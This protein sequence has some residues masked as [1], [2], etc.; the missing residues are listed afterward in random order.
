MAWKKKSALTSPGTPE[1]DSKTT[2]AGKRR[3]DSERGDVEALE[4][5]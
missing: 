4:V 3:K 1:F 2:E 5:C